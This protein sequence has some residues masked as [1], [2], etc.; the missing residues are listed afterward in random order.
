MSRLLLVITI[1]FIT[2]LVY[3]AQPPIYDA[4]FNQM[5]NG[6]SNNDIGVVVTATNKPLNFNEEVVIYL[7]V[8][9]FGPV[10]Q[11]AVAVFSL[12]FIDGLNLPVAETCDIIIVFPSPLERGLSGF[13]IGWAIQNLGINETRTCEITLPVSSVSSGT[14]KLRFTHT[15]TAND[16]NNDNDLSEI[17]LEYQ[18]I[19]IPVP[20]LSWGGLLVMVLLLLLAGVRQLVTTNFRHQ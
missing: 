4:L 11:N 10:Q 7:H 15:A 6:P 19:T 16:P 3:A 14:E 18:G 1:L 20:A 5:D 9:N 2:P 8:Q 17:T 13:S 12:D